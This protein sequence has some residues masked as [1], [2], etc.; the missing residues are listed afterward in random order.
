ML[1]SN[2]PMDRQLHDGDWIRSWKQNLENIS[3]AKGW[4]STF[5]A[6]GN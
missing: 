5:I 6:V 4:L 3:V 2:I 1:W